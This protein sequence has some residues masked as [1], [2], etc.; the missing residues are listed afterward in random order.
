[1]FLSLLSILLLVGSPN[2]TPSP[3]AT[4]TPSADTTPA[5][6]VEMCVAEQQSV[7]NPNLKVGI[8]FRN[9]RDV[10]A[11]HVA[12]DV[13]NVNGDGR[14][15]AYH[16]VSMDGHFAPNVLVVPRRAPWT[17]ALLMQSEYPDS[18]AWSVPNHFGSGASQVR[19]VP[20]SATFKDG[21]VWKRTSL[22][23]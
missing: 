23:E 19:C 20:D 9:L 5:I 22:D 2:A 7:N 13:L 14:V 21:S 8:G 18:P 15:L 3:A 17:D 1:M 6:A 4:S 12:F 10:E 16:T 11:I